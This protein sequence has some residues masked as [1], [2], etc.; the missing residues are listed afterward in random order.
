[1]LDSLFRPESVAVIGASRNPAKLGHGI[2][3]NI[4]DSEFG[5]AIYPVNPTAEKILGHRV[6]PTVLDIP[7]ELQ[8]AVVVIPA[9]FVAQVLEECGQKGVGTAVIISAGF[10]EVGG[11]GLRRE[12]RL[13]EIARKYNMRLLGPNCLGVIDTSAPLNA[14]FAAAMPSQ[15]PIAFMSQSGA[16]CTAVLDVA[17]GE[18]VGFS[19]FVSLGNK[20]DL[21]EIDFIQAWR[22]DPSTRVVMAYLEGISEGSR[23]I[24]VA[25]QATKSLPI[26]A[27]KSGTTA[28]GS[29]AVSSHTGTLAGSEQAYEAAF[30]R[31]GIIRAR[32]VEELF[33]F[34]IAFA[35]QP[36]LRE[37]SIAIITNAGGP[38]IMCTDACEHAGLHLASLGPGASARLRHGLPPAASVLNPID[39][40]GDAQADRYDLAIR[41][42]LSD[43]NVSGLIVLLTPQNVTPIEETARVIGEIA[44]QE[45]EKPVLAC[46]M[47]RATIAPGVKILNEY[48]VPNYPT[49]ERA[50]KAMQVMLEQRLWQEQPERRP[51]VFQV[52]KSCVEELFADVR[53]EGRVM[54]GD[55][56]ARA[57]LEAYGIP[58]PRSQLAETPEKAV[59]IARQIGYPV[60]MKI[61]SPDILHKT[62]IG[63][64]RLDIEDDQEVRDYF[65]LLTYRAMRYMAEAEIWGC[66]VQDMVTGGREV[67]LGMNRDPQ[68]GPLLMF[69]LG[70]IYVEALRDVTFRLAPLSPEDAQEMVQ[71]IRGYSLLRGVRGESAVDI[72]GIVDTLLRI[73]QLVIDFPEVVELD[74]NPL[75]VHDHGQG[76]VG[77]DMRL[78]LR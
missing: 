5:G 12:H 33:D 6:Y 68:F 72:E 16:L 75:V 19:S 20:A 3:K 1:M 42:A 56:E 48:R 60:A 47:G 69:G 27:I 54:I 49:P 30:E 8:Q 37:N 44:D 2:L 59:D 65:D 39:V 35:R 57:V 23:F 32:S 26:I 29:R 38:G 77:I 61:A 22:D 21:N 9:P 71:E 62:D 74:I 52:D 45:E 66:L 25:G 51:K 67:I 40:L 73:S 7:G 10:R 18:E 31:A 46:F 64:V 15:G 4:I 50:V 17:L 13:V 76:V 11:E 78:V 63:G 53:A 41:A 36:L 14:S 28:A 34:S 70:G 24:E 58:V 43:S 55:A